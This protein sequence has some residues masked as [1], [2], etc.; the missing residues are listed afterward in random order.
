MKIGEIGRLQTLLHGLLDAFLNFGP[1]APLN[2]VSS[3]KAIRYR[4]GQRPSE[5]VRILNSLGCQEKDTVKAWDKLVATTNSCSSEDFAR[6]LSTG[7]VFLDSIIHDIETTSA[8]DLP[9]SEM[10]RSTWMARIHTNSA[11]KAVGQ[12]CDH[13]KESHKFGI[14]QTWVHGSLGT[15]D[16]VAGYSDFDA[17]V[18]LHR[19]SYR[20][21]SGLFALREHIRDLCACLYLYDPLQHHGLF[22]V[23]DTD[24]QAYPQAY[25]PLEL[26]RHAIPVAGGETVL[27]AFLRDDSRERMDS[28]MGACNTVR[29]LLARSFGKVTA[30]DLKSLLQTVVLLPVL[31]LQLRDGIYRY[32]KYVYDI[33]KKDFSD[34]EWKII[35]KITA[36]RGKWK[37]KSFL[38]YRM[39]RKLFRLLGPKVMPVFHR[40]ESV[41]DT[42]KVVKYIGKDFDSDV[43]L[44]VEAMMA[45][46]KTLGVLVKND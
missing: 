9:V 13:A 18:I 32:K 38:S 12:F 43:A 22:V 3:A 41:K 44:L 7:Y 46:A 28:F 4:L 42:Y 34:E 17:L 5:V 8:V 45:K 6:A 19:E 15:L 40:I 29:M 20:S 11:C 39:R 31:Y 10:D 21:A 37:Y 24:L 27:R 26:F 25:F 16:G 23:T 1:V 35:D 14:R 2:V 36:L 30:Y 33:A